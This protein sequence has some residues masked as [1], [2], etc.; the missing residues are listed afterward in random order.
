MDKDFTDLNNIYEVFGIPDAISN[1][2]EDAERGLQDKFSQVDRIAEANQYKVLK[3]MQEERLSDTHFNWN[4]GYGY[5]DAGRDITERIFAKVFGGDAALVRTAF[6]NGT[7]ALAASLFGILRPGDGLVYVSGKPYD[8]LEEVIGIRGQGMGSLREYGVTYKQVDLK[9]QYGDAE[10]PFDFEGI[11]DA[12]DEKTKVCAIQRAT[13]YSWRRSITME[14]I[15]Q[16]TAY[17][18][19]INPEIIIFVDNCYGEFLDM[20]EPL[21]V[22]CDLMAGSLIKNPGGGLALSG[23][24]SIGRKDLVEKVSY[25]LSCPGIGGECG[26]TYGQT[27]TMLQ[28]LFMAPTVVAGAIKGAM[29]C[30]EVFSELGF[31]VAPSNDQPR[32]DIIQAIQ[33]GSKERL[34]SFCKGIQ[35][36]A[37]VDSFVTPEPWPMPGYDSDVVMAAGAFVQGSSIELSADGPVKPPYN[38]YFQGGMTYSHSKMGVLFA[39]KQLYKEGLVDIK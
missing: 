39:L 2:V 35:A 3:A 23:G 19:S 5:D 14:E 9:P 12:I 26:L 36:A 16:V 15:S 17:I 13:G 37:P 24:Y 28:G 38:V 4:T 8:T 33:L 29:I 25:R 30:G 20:R 34:V 1:L 27:R 6:V 11:R 18:K 21:D 7:H 10:N 22:G 32:S 31:P